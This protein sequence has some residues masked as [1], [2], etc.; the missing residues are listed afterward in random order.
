M[1]SGSNE[2]AIASRLRAQL[3][4]RDDLDQRVADVRVGLSYTAVRLASG[5]TGVALTFKESA[6]E[7]CCQSAD[8]RPYAGRSAAELVEMLGSTKPVESAIGLACANALV[9]CLEQRYDPGDILDRL[10]LRPDDRVG[11][12]GD[13]QPIV[14]RLRGL[15]GSLTIFERIESPRGALRPAAE[16]IECLPGCDVALV[17]ATTIINGTIDKVLSAARDCREVVL[18]GASTPLLPAAFAGSPVTLLSGIL[19]PDPEPVLRTVSEGGGMHIFKRFV[20]K[21]NLLPDGAHERNET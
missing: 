5:Q 13:F 19:I 10:S 8:P 6:S 17:T 15:V 18:L 21:V 12:V 1:G 16:A 4:M 7:H 11:M 20:H 2:R 14:R 9:N 3:A